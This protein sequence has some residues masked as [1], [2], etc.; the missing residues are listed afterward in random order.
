MSKKNILQFR[1]P[2]EGPSITEDLTNRRLFRLEKTQE[3]PGDSD[4]KS[5]T[6][7]TLL[8]SDPKLL[9]ELIRWRAAENRRVEK[10]IQLNLKHMVYPIID[11]LRE[12][13]SPSKRNLIYLLESCL[14]DILSPMILVLES[15]FHTLS[16]TEVEICSMISKGYST[17]HIASL[18]NISGLTIND[19]RKSIRKKL[20]LTNTKK[21]LV[22]Y[23]KSCFKS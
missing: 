6:G 10:Q 22:S 18:K 15:K 16:P 17:K 23:L 2:E 9:E 7:S 13:I 1:R 12:H 21:N 20:G 19:H 11:T 8:N 4:Q 5:M 3:K 14:R